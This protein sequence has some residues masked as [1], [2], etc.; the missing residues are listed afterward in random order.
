MSQGRFA[1]IPARA[2]DDAELG[3]AALKVLLVLGTHAD[4][5]GWCFPSQ[6]TVAD[7]LGVSRQAVGKQI[8]ALARLGY[9]EIHK[10]LRPDGR[11]GVNRYRVLYDPELPAERDT[12]LRDGGNL[13]LPPGQPPG[14]AAGAT[15]RG[16]GKREGP[17]ENDETNTQRARE[18]SEDPEVSAFATRAGLSAHQV[19]AE[20]EAWDRHRRARGL[21]HADEAAAFTGWLDH[22][23]RAGKIRPA[24]PEGAPEKA[25]Q[26][27]GAWG[28]LEAAELPE[29]EA[30]AWRAA[31]RAVAAKYGHANVRAYLWPAQPGRIHE[32]PHGPGGPPVLVAEIRAA[33]AYAQGR[34]LTEYELTIAEALGAELGNQRVILTVQGPREKP[35]HDNRP[36]EFA[37]D[38]PGDAVRARG[39]DQRDADPRSRRA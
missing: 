36:G 26:D 27:P 21:E 3:A 14:V 16:C 25:S 7:R 37:N 24:R 4:R 17:T 23:I 28:E 12:S 5:E 8:A 29:L 20:L 33:T 34:I 38:R 30:A 15:P 32:N 1:I 18:L 11:Q 35:S 22:G 39:R 2:L 31:A 19:A 6:D 13:T 9:L 10:T